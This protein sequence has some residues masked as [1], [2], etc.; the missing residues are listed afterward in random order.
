MLA[1]MAGARAKM[2]SRLVNLGKHLFLGLLFLLSLVPLGMLLLGAGKTTHQFQ[3]SPYQLTLPYH[4]EHYWMMARGMS[5]YILNSS[6]VSTVAISLTLVF[7]SYGAYNFA[8]FSFPGKDLLYYAVITLMMIPF[9]LYL[10]PQY[11]LVLRLGMIDSLWALIWPYTAGG[12]V[13]G[14]FLIRPFI[15]SLPQALFESARIDGASEWQEFWYIALPLCR[16]IMATLAIIL[17]LGQ[18]NDLIWPAVT[19][20][21]SPQYTVALGVFSIA[22]VMQVSGVGSATSMV[23][24]GQMFA[25]FA[26]SAVPLFLV[27]IVA[28]RV[29][30]KGLTSGALK[31]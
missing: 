30:V 6:I 15:A 18:W 25:A 19:L 11:V 31:F 22:S 28:R 26:I 4:F 10:V 8:R 2:A 12:T 1:R 14:L 21:R 16:P 13:L 24:W 17:L 9:V 23:Q 7:A 29:F 20:T 5:R 3:A 27:F